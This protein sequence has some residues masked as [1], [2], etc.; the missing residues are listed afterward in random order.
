MGLRRKAAHTAANGGFRATRRFLLAQFFQ[1][2]QGM[3]PLRSGLR[4]LPWTAMP[5]F[6][7][8]VAGSF[9]DGL[10]GGQRVM[11]V[12]LALQS[13]GLIWI[14]AVT[15]TTTP[16]S[17]L[18]LPFILSVAGMALFFTPVANVVLGSVRPEHEG[19]ASGANNAIRELG[20]VFG[21]AVL[22][23]VFAHMGGYR[24]ATTFVHGTTTAVYVGGAVVALGAVA[25]GLAGR[26]TVK[27]EAAEE[28]EALLEA[29]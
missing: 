16:Y 2:V 13:A 19:K 15:T 28:Q 20:G 10:G 8:P 6:I 14:A 27:V 3:S 12:G 5:I 11:T 4:I 29:A 23:S 17:H 21:V 25:A 1:T 9:L 26:R 24:S 18:V 7:A 22:A